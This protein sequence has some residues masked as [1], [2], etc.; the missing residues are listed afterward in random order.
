LQHEVNRLKSENEKLKDGEKDI[1]RELKLKAKHYK[2]IH[3]TLEDDIDS[4][5]DLY[6]EVDDIKEDSRYEEKAQLIE[7]HLERAHDILD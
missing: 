1:I 5:R 2:S 7:K 6:K 4:L 3:K